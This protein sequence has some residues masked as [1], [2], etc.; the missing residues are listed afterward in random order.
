MKKSDLRKVYRLAKLDSVS[1]IQLY[2]S[3]NNYLRGLSWRRLA[4]IL[5]KANRIRASAGLDPLPA[6]PSGQPRTRTGGFP[7]APN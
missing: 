5:T 7:H 1:A 6:I 3:N 4:P 2:T